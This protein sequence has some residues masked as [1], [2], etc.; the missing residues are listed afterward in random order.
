MKTIFII[1]LLLYLTKYMF[2]S[3]GPF[4]TCGNE[5]PKTLK[6]CDKYTIKMGIGCCLLTEV[7]NNNK[8]SCLLIGGK[9]QG[10]FN[11]QTNPVNLSNLSF[12][13]DVYNK[14]DEERIKYTKE[15]AEKYG[16]SS[17]GVIRCKDNK[18]YILNML[19]ILMTIIGIIFIF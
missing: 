3:W 19:L 9:A 2:S 8:T 17:L 7:S 18:S 16:N 13:F 10:F 6:D 15:I 1:T 11:N 5:D 14:T 4:Q 12:P